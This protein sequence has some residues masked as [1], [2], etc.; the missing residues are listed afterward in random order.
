MNGSNRAIEHIIADR[1]AI[2]RRVEP[3]RMI[4]FD[5]YSARCR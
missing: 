5:R 2:I 3:I 4:N 1:K